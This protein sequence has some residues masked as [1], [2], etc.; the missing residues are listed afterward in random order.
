MH[1]PPFPPPLRRKGTREPSVSKHIS[2]F[3]DYPVAEYLASLPLDQKI[4]HRV[5]KRVLI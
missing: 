1:K 4:R 2:P 5:T 3:L